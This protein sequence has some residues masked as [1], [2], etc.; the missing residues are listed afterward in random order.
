MY[1]EDMY[2]VTANIAKIPA[3]SIP[4]GMVEDRGDQLP[5]GLQL[6]GN[7]WDEGTLLD[8]AE[9]IEERS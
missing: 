4:M 2:T 9:Q 3:M 1:L 7:H 6:M 8:I 5:V